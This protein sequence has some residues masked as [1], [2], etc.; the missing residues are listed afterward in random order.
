MVK[1]LKVNRD[2]LTTRLPMPSSLA[3]PATED[4]GRHLILG[5]NPKATL[6]EGAPAEMRKRCTPDNARR[7]D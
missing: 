2:L 4:A 7:A 3:N 1:R 6:D 5:Y